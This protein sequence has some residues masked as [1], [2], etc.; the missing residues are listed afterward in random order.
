MVAASLIGPNMLPTKLPRMIQKPVLLLG[1]AIALL[2]SA[3]CGS[4]DGE[5]NTSA[6]STVTVATTSTS[7]DNPST[8]AAT[9]SS[10]GE[11]ID[12]TFDGE[13]CSVDVAPEIPAG[14]R[15]FR[16][17]NA[18]ELPIRIKVVLLN[19][20]KSYQDLIAIETDNGGP[21]NS[22][23]APTWVQE[24]LISFT[25]VEAEM[26]DRQTALRYDLE[27]GP[28]AVIAFATTSPFAVWLCG[29]LN[30]ADIGN[31]GTAEITEV[32]FDGVVC[33][34]TGP[35]EVATGAHSFV[36]TDLTGEG[37]A[38]VRTM[39]ISADHTYEDLLALQ[40]ETGEYVPKPEWAEWPLTTFESVE[41]ELGKDE[42][43][44]RLILEPGIHGIVVGT[45]KGIW[46]CGPLTVTDT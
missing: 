6:A 1:L 37:R 25:P 45:G 3:G 14:D 24:A 20:G 33:T 9:I 42:V 13:G 32:T 5:A 35:S 15:I 4:S 10:V 41:R 23:S 31:I 12:V 8:T 22:W 18:S 44:K 43:G 38:D 39:A 2:A 40:S 46:F 30:V 21:G 17:T 28:H 26:A 29:P 19:D 11:T 16:Y 34:T 7:E 36:L 27:P